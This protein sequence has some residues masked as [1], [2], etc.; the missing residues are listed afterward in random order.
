MEDRTFNNFLEKLKYKNI[1][2][3]FVFN[4]IL[5]IS[6]ILKIYLYLRY[7]EGYMDS[8][9]Y[10]M[11]ARFFAENGNIYGKMPIVYT[12]FAAIILSIPYILLKNPGYAIFQCIQMIFIFFSGTQIYYL[13][14]KNDLARVF[15]IFIALT[16]ILIVLN[17]NDRD[18]KLE[19]FVLVFLL[20]ALMA[21]DFKIKYKYFFV[22]FFI[23]VA[24]WCKQYGL[25]FVPVA[26]FAIFKE[27]YQDSHIK[28]EKV[29]FNISML[30]SGFV[31]PL[32][33]SLFFLVSTNNKDL[34]YFI[35]LYSGTFK[36][37]G[38]GVTG[39]G[40]NYF[41]LFR[42][43]FFVFVYYAQ[44]YILIPFLYLV[45]EKSNSFYLF[46][47]R[48]I[49]IYILTICFS[50]I[51]FKFAYY[52]NYFILLI[53]FCLLFVLEFLV[54][55]ASKIRKVSILRYSILLLILPAFVSF[56]H[57]AGFLHSIEKKEH[58]R[59][60][61]INIARQINKY[62]PPYS[63]A[64][65]V[66]DQYDEGFIY[67]SKFNPANKDKLVSGGADGY[68]P[69]QL[70]D[71]MIEGSFVIINKTIVYYKMYLTYI[72]EKDFMYVSEVGDYII[73]KKI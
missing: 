52:Y 9:Y 44:F 18:I 1:Q 5:I 2:F 51:Q 14:R 13:I 29:F 32:V 36:I 33:L 3:I 55:S 23:F 7:A 15:C 62:V 27:H 19:P 12:P 26:A 24:F 30:F 37:T 6:L 34:I 40:W 56:Y 53:P 50:C 70:I 66:G 47:E 25:F 49:Q 11:M 10:L 69:K 20:M 72:K 46:K 38:I 65:I 43:I 63:P 16:H 58:R 39:I 8:P 45:L 61:R 35:R 41:D 42:A 68:L 54:L 21:L 22:G 57:L 60:E 64:I 17:L 4:I 73:F 31:L 67:L 48:R 71:N 59:I 28:I